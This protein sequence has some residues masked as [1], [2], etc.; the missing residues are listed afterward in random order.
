M[1]EL[2]GIPIAQ[3][4]VEGTAYLGV[5]D[6]MDGVPYYEIESGR[7]HVEL[8]RFRQV[9][10]EAACDLESVRRHVLAEL[11]QAPSGIFAAHLSLVRDP[12]LTERVS[13]RIRGDLVNAEQA[14]AAEITILAVGLANV[15]DDYFRQRAQDIRDVGRR[16]IWRLLPRGRGEFSNLPAGSVVVAR[17]LFPSDTLDLD[18]L[19][20][21]DIV[22][23]Q[24]GETSH[25]AILARSLGIPAVTGVFE[26]SARIEQGQTLIVDGNTGRVVVAPEESQRCE[27]SPV[28]I[29]AGLRNTRSR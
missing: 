17:Q 15:Q 28:T 10:E 26:A 12:S 3:G 24:G 8:E 6:D 20:L 2:T 18:R 5:V 29:G 27:L 14:V 7:V 25:F 4:I 16:I 11:G 9:I 19:H 23:E 13:A 1:F 21:A 22:T